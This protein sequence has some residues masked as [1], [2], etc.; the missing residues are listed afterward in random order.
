MKKAT[1][2]LTLCLALLGG[3]ANNTQAPETTATPTPETE[4]GDPNQKAIDAMKE[5][6]GWTETSTNRFETD[7]SWLNDDTPLDA[8]VYVDFAEKKMGYVVTNEE[9]GIFIETDYDWA[10]RQLTYQ[11]SEYDL[12]EAEGACQM[13]LGYR[14]EELISQSNC[15]EANAASLVNEFDTT[16]NG[17]FSNIPIIMVNRVE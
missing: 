8:H 10:T 6:E 1:L 9:L 13:I 4:S 5:A 2:L 15:A 17:F 7:T 11:N 14:S 12:E 16:M 3:C